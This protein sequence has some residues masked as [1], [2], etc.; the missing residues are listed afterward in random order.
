MFVAAKKSFHNKGMLTK[1]NTFRLST[2]YLRFA[3]LTTVNENFE[4]HLEIVVI[5]FTFKKSLQLLRCLKYVI[6]KSF[7]SLPENV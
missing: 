4:F 3:D 2:E 1:W 5:R 7:K 6:E